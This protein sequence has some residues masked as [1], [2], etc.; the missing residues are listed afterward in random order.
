[1]VHRFT[2]I[3]ILFSTI[4]FYT[5]SDKI[6]DNPIG[7]KTPTTK[8]FL[9]TIHA[10]SLVSMQPSKIQLFWTGDDPDGFVAGFYFSWDNI[11]WTFTTANDSLFA[12]QIGDVNAVFTFRVAAVDNN[13]N[14]SYDLTVSRNG[15]NFGPEPFTDA[16]SNGKWDAGE[17]FTD[18]G[19][20]D[21]NPAVLKL[22]IR[23][24][25]P[26][27][28]W[29]VLSTVPDSSFPVMSFSWNGT[30]LDGNETITAVRLAMNDTASSV[31][32]NGSVRTITLRTTEFTSSSPK[33]DI[34]IDGNASNIAP[35][36]LTGLKFNDLNVLWVSLV[37]ISGASSKWISSD[38]LNK[39]KKWFVKKPKGKLLI[40][41]DYTIN[42]KSAAFYN[43]MMDSIGLT[44][45][46]DVIDLKAQALPFP[47]VT[48]YE[49]MKLFGYT[50]WYS[51][52]N[53]PSLDLAN[54]TVA[55]YLDQGGKIFFSMQFPTNVDLNTV[56]GFL[57]ISADSSQFT[58]FIFPGGIISADTNDA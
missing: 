44:G 13:G 54:A 22:P 23:N 49:T 55:K 8:V 6:V 47:N 34:L 48:F 51:D 58:S 19:D 17:P 15:V 10:D 16:N 38:S 18:I 36:K 7:N 11:N 24:T 12:L 50:F 29:N 20:V 9:S 1:M 42:D 41:D 30:D 3:L 39:N 25:A 26:T 56:Q 32:I 46:F 4:V 27:I 31:S 5:C 57:P 43:S 21:P 52:Y 33:L 53:A 40:V 35:V 37:D 28:S 2:Y 45:K 14:G